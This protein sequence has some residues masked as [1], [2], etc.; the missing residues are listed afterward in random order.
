GTPSFLPT[1]ITL[2]TFPNKPAASSAAALP[3]DLAA[4]RAEIQAKLAA[5]SKGAS[6]VAPP[7]AAP[8]PPPASKL[9]AVPGLPRPNL[10]PDLAKKVAEAKRLVE[11][12]QQKKLAMAKPANPYLSEPVVDSSSAGRGGLSMTAHP[13]LMDTSA[14]T[15]QSKKDRYKPMAPKFSTAKANARM[16]TAPAK[17]IAAPAAP[18]PETL[19]DTPYFDNRLSYGGAKLS[20]KSHMGRGHARDTLKFNQKGKFVRQGEAIRAEAKMEELK[21][22][23]MESARKAGLESEME[24]QARIIKRAP[25]PEV[26]WWDTPFLPGK[27]YESFTSEHLETSDAITIYVQHPIQIPAPGDKIK[28]QPRDLHLTKKELKKMRRQRRL[29]EQQDKQ[30]RVKMGLL[31]PPPPKVKLSNMMRVLTQDAIADPTKVEA[32]VRREMTARARGHDQ[33]NAARKLTDEQRR[34]KVDNEHAKDESKGIFA[35]CFRVRY[36]SNRQHK[37]KVKKNAEQLRLTGVLIFNPKF[38]FVLVEGGAKSIKLYKRLM[39]HRI[40]WTEEA[41]PREGEDREDDPEASTSG[42]GDGNP[43]MEGLEEPE[44][45]ADNSCELVW[46]GA[47]REKMF[48]YFKL[49]NCPAESNAKEVLG[50]KL[51]GLWDTAKTY[52]QDED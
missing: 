29:A 25:P 47:H 28:V 36:L 3:F 20:S 35:A 31:P 41:L 7:A 22:R 33:A 43:A 8:P 12:M 23:I 50:A 46:E 5:M 24:D 13:L 49:H 45:L 21:K 40:D 30:D 37:F 32:Q 4:K 38:C 6:A 17:P 15:A 44:S 9:P 26:E 10:D 48:N 52:G 34:A 16:P 42:V 14:P 11:S 19:V 18:E 51:E 1:P 2:N 27:D 39:L